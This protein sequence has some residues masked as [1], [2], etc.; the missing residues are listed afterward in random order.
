VVEERFD[1]EAFLSSLSPHTA[2]AIVTGSI[3]LGILAAVET[4]VWSVLVASI[5]LS[6]LV[7]YVSTWE[8]PDSVTKTHKVTKGGLPERKLLRYLIM[9]NERTQMEVE[10]R[11]QAEKDALRRQKGY[12]GFRGGP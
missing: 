3:T 2:S 12:S 11:E 4:G 7:G 9:S 6:L 10:E 8:V 1:V 5:A